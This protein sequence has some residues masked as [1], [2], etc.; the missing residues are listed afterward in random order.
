MTGDDDDE[1][2][3]SRAVDGESCEPAAAGV[4]VCGGVCV[5]AVLGKIVFTGDDTTGGARSGMGDDGA[6]R[7]GASGV[8]ASAVGVCSEVACGGLGGTGCRI[9]SGLPGFMA[10]TFARVGPSSA[11]AG[12][13]G[14]GDVT[15][16][17]VSGPSVRVLCAALTASITALQTRVKCTPLRTASCTAVVAALYRSWSTGVFSTKYRFCLLYTSPS[18]RD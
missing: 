13:G 18:P 16:S 3:A 17:C 11:G 7:C 4:L 12:A 6:G 9:R 8:G 14:V 15:P 10:A 1:F 5:V 2:G